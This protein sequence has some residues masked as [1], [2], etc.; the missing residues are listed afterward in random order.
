MGNNFWK[1]KEVL[2]TGGAGFIGS[3][4][5]EML[6][7]TGA[8]ITVPIFNGKI[9]F[10]NNVKDK[11][12]IINANLLDFKNCLDLTHKKDIIM[13][14]AALVG[15]LEFNIKHPGSIFRNNLL[16][17]MNVLEAARQNKVA[18][19]LTVSSACVYPRYCTIPTPEEEGF[20]DRPE[21]TNEGYGWA[22]RMEEFMS[23][24]YMKE[25]RM[26]IAVARPYNAY[27]PRD[28][29]NPK[30]SHVIPAIIKRVLDEENPLVIWGNGQQSRAFLYV[31]DFCRGLMVLTEKCD[32]AKAINLGTDKE[33]SIKELVKQ[34]LKVT[35]KNPEVIFDISKPTGQPRRNCDIT[36]AKQ[37]GFEAIV[38]LEEG[39]KKTV[40]WYLKWM[41]K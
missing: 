41:K 7:E 39:L 23:K 29:F 31:T 1:G 32:D 24:A 22:K 14:L 34:I 25:Y 5:I 18:N 6:I 26:K 35:G 3:H 30:S 4:L 9:D 13:N 38:P 16:I 10:L 2:V 27:G 19:F 8:K 28:N 12:T 15:G 20:K 21:P 33:V 11:I 40:A 37:L 17:F 36:K